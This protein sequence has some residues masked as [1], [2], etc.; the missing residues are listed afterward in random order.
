MHRPVASTV[1]DWLEAKDGKLSAAVDFIDLSKAFTTVNQQKLL[2]S[3]QSYDLGGTVLSWFHDYVYRR[4]SQVLI[5]AE[6]SSFFCV[7]KGVPQGSV[8][9]L[10]TFDV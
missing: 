9:G 3:V 10:L 2:L 4:L 1:N 6:S 7:K 8:L 5:N